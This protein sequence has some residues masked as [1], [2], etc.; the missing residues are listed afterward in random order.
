MK[1]IITP[2]SADIIS[3]SYNARMN[4]LHSYLRPDGRNAIIEPLRRIAKGKVYTQ[5][6]YFKPTESVPDAAIKPE[7]VGN[8][9]D[10]RF[11]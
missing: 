8:I 2:K 1:P 11:G 9:I 6:A 3:D 7:G 4:D 5:A 10:F